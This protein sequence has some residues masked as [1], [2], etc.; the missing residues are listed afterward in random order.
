ME[1]ACASFTEPIAKASDELSDMASD[2]AAD[3]EG[4]VDAWSQVVDTYE[5]AVAG[6]SNAEVQAAARAAADNLAE[7]RDAME[8]AFVD[9]D[10]T[11]M[12]VFTE[13]TAAFQESQSELMELCAG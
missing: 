9:K 7:L 5:S 12:G 10:A 1:E 8:K 13:A 3:P 2:A 6:V 4:A 11:A